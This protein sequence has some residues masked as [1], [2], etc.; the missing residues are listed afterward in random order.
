MTK[1]IF[2]SAAIGVGMLIGLHLAMNG[3]LG[4][5]MRAVAGTDIRAAAG[6]NTFFWM[7]GAFTAFIFYLIFQPGPFGELFS[8]STKPLLLA[9]A[10]GASLVFAV[11]FLIPDRVG[12]AANG[13][14]YLVIGQIVMGM[15]LSHN[16]WL[17]SPVDPFS[18]KKAGGLVLIAAGVF[19]SVR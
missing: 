13:F 3:R 11:T 5:D 17:G 1:L 2:A 9:G 7:I 10:M 19:L 18:M 4:G 14:I 8:V 12:G 16:G 6:A 15:I